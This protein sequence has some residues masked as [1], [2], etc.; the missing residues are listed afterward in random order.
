[1]VLRQQIDANIRQMLAEQDKEAA[2]HRGTLS[3]I[4]ED[5]VVAESS[6][7]ASPQK[8]LRMDKVE[9]NKES[10][11]LSPKSVSPS[12]SA[13][14]KSDLNTPLTQKSSAKPEAQR[15]INRQRLK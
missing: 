7:T 6:N 1:M 14:S 11:I 5:P 4:V 15:A 9:E 8:V 12:K 13:L 3:R 2:Y 10:A